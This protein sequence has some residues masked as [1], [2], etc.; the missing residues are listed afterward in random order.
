MQQGAERRARRAPAA[1]A[2][3]GPGRAGRGGGLACRHENE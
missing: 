2:L 1:V 3:A